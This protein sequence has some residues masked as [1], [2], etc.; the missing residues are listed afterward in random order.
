MTNPQKNLVAMAVGILLLLFMLLAFP[1]MGCCASPCPD[2]PVGYLSP[3]GM[4][5][6]GWEV[7]DLQQDQTYGFYWF[8]LKQKDPEST[9][10]YA[11]LVMA[12]GV[13]WPI[14]YNYLENGTLRFLRLMGD[15][16]RY[17]VDPDVTSEDYNVVAKYYERFL[18]V[19]VAPR[20]GV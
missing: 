3:A 1:N 17:I 20:T 9:V 14:F 16:S 4:M 6:T 5:G 2:V 10:L 18:G 15:R 7:R 13:D 8:F 11:N 12:V 19:F